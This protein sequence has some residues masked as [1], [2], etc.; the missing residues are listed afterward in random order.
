[1]KHNPMVRLGEKFSPAFHRFE[2]TGFAF[3]PQLSVR[4]IRF[5]GHKTDQALGLMDIEIIDHKMPAAHGRVGCNRGLNMVEVVLFGAGGATRNLTNLPG[6][7]LK[8]DDE[9]ERAVP[10]VFKLPS[11]DFA[12][13]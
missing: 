12:G 11:F 8:I 3:D 4:Q 9:T 10:N 2:N 1:M 5:G 13:T 7:N 6:G